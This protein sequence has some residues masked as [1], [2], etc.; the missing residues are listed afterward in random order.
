MLKLITLIEYMTE[1]RKLALGLGSILKNTFSYQSNITEYENVL[2]VSYFNL[3][4][5]ST[6]VCTKRLCA[7]YL[8]GRS[9]PN[10]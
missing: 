1:N 9:E 5:P 3:C 10:I 4:A 2:I 7:P 6:P 8:K